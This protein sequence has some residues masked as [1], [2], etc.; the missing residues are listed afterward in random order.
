MTNINKQNE[1][2]DKEVTEATAAVNK[3]EEEYKKHECEDER[4]M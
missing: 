4:R 1:M 2:E 3:N